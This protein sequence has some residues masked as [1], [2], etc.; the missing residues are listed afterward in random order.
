LLVFGGPFIILW[1]GEDFRATIDVLYILAVAAAIYLPQTVANSVL[2]GVSKHKVAFYI[3]LGESVSKISLSVILLHY[4]GIIGVALGTA[5][6]QLI[7]YIF[8]YP[9][10]F[11][12]VMGATASRFYLI[13]FRSLVL[14]VIFI[15]PVSFAFSKLVVPDSWL[16]LMIDCFMAGIIMLA[17]LGIFILESGDRERIL[18][19]FKSM[20]RK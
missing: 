15:L 19:K 16:K 4:F 9:H 14:S 5:I 12:R 1:V 3:L 7:I 6:P 11:H 13:A 18:G 10:A 8:I 20:I 17:G 2:F